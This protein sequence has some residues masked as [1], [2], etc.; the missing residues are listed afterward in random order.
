MLPLRRHAD[1]VI[2]VLLLR[3]HFFASSRKCQLRRFFISRHKNTASLCSPGVCR[4]FSFS[5]IPIVPQPFFHSADAPSSLRGFFTA[6]SVLP[7]IFHFTAI[8][9]EHHG[10]ISEAD[11]TP[12]SIFTIFPS[13]PSRLL[14]VSP[15]AAPG[16]IFRFSFGHSRSASCSRSASFIAPP[17]P[18]KMDDVFA[19]RLFQP[20]AATPPSSMSAADSRRRAISLDVL[21]PQA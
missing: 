13:S 1:S 5:R 14:C 16:A 8:I 21:R 11:A 18:L 20:C 15:P 9:A 4:G 17:A 2:S 10:A 19:D 3:L 6:A 7:L 12:I